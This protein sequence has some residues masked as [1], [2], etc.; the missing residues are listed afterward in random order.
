MLTDSE[1]VLA[2][3]AVVRQVERPEA[4]DAIRETCSGHSVVIQNVSFGEAQ[5]AGMEVCESRG[6]PRR[7]GAPLLRRRR[8]PASLW[9]AKRHLGRA[10]NRTARVCQ[11]GCEAAD[12]SGGSVGGGAGAGRMRT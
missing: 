3:R 7:R 4:N 1:L 2:A 8:S 9:S 10:A 12:E 11:T 6:H 5:P